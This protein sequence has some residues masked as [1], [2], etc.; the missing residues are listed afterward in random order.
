TYVLGTR[1][2]GKTSLLRQVETQVPAIFLDLQWA[3]GR[4]EDLARQARREMRRKRRRYPW[5]PPHDGLP[6]DLFELLEAANDAIEEAR[7]RLWVL[8]DEAEIW[9]RIARSDPEVLHRLRGI[10]QNCPALR[11]VLV[12]SK[13]LSEA[14]TL[15]GEGGS[16]FLSGFALRY[17]GP[18]SPRDGA[19]LL[20]QEQGTAPVTV[21]RELLIKLL[22][23]T[24]GHPLLLQL[25][26]ERLHE[27]G[28]L[29]APTEGDLIGILDQG[30]K[31]GVF[32]QDFAALSGPERA[33]LGAISSDQPLPADTDAAYLHGLAGLGIL[34]REGDGYA[35]G[36]DFFARW[37][38]ERADW[39]ARSEVSAE[40]TLTVY[41][42]SELEPALAKTER[43]VQLRQILTDHFNEGELHTLCFDLGVDYDDL[44]GEG[45]ANKAR[46]LVS[47][48]ERRKRIPELVELVKKRRPRISWGD[49]PEKT[50]DPNQGS[51][52]PT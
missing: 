42:Q 4:L 10:V 19:A 49:T 40:G 24:G 43:Q 7:E 36:N 51:E 32:P 47:Y 17:L 6:D 14:N 2:I 20:R 28:R 22:A 21:H 37:L 9:V 29:R 35:I 8:I 52:R 46:E 45:K 30:G 15:T 5:L 48:L 3:G 26:G 38:Q 16:P 27:E 41:T 11:V 39:Q 31:T 13:S 23:L 18:L 50:K 34:R 44:P 33:I 1:Q 25:L 12:A